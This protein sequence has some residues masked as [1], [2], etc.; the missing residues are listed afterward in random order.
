MHCSSLLAHPEYNEG[1]AIFVEGNGHGF[2]P[3][4][5][6]CLPSVDLC[7]W[8][9][10]EVYMTPP[11]ISWQSTEAPQICT[12]CALHTSDFVARKS[13]AGLEAGS[14]CLRL[15]NING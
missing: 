8:L 4:V 1:P 13:K 5:A 10:R 3:L 6:S 14:S 7:P 2:Q 9:T 12:V 15:L 11:V